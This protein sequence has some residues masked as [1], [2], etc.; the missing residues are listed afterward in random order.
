MRAQDWPWHV[1]SARNSISN[2]GEDA[3]NYS[4]GE[5]EGVSKVSRGGA[6]P[7][8]G[9]VDR[10]GGCE[11]AVCEVITDTLLFVAHL[12]NTGQV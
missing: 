7:G 3:I 11:A 9:R 8:R 10:R 1:P 12:K 2:C 5:Q 4:E 6:V